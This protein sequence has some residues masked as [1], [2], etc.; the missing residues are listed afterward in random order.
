MK[1]EAAESL[2]PQQVIDPI[3]GLGKPF[4]AV[5]VAAFNVGQLRFW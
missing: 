3:S 1:W 2:G 4:A 5:A